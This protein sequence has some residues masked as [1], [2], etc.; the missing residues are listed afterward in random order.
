[1]V[2]ITLPA[3]LRQLA[4]QNKTTVYDLLFTEAAETLKTFG[5]NHK[6]LNARLGMTGVQHTQQQ[7]PTN[8][9][10]KTYNMI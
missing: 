9:R 7:F 1:M 5:H 8:I 6:G 10:L 3:Q 4:W 2:T